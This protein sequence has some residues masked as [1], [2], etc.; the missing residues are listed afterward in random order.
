MEGLMVKE[1][2]RPIF[3]LM[4]DKDVKIKI[5]SNG[6]VTGLPGDEKW[7]VFNAMSVIMGAFKE[8]IRQVNSEN[9]ETW[10]K[11]HLAL[12]GIDI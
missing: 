10:P 11:E 3:E 2:D 4:N 12:Y 9:K 6:V 1:N 5:Y 7:A 8:E